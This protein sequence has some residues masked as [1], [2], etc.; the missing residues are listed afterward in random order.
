M[1][2]VVGQTVRCLAPSIYAGQ[3]GVIVS[4]DESR[5]MVLRGGTRANAIIY[6]EGVNSGL[7]RNK[8]PAAWDVFCEVVSPVT[9]ENWRL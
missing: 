4:I 6:L 5:Q 3:E 9:I 1:N 7:F 8:Q 2:F